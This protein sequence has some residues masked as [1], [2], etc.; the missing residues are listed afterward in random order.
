LL[1]VCED[2]R[3]ARKLGYYDR[4]CKGTLQEDPYAV[5]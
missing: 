2:C 4:H 5:S 1:S 3:V